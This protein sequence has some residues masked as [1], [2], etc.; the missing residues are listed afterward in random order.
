MIID[1]DT[2]VVEDEDIWKWVSK[3]EAR[4]KPITISS[5]EVSHAAYSSG[6]TKF[7]LID[8][9][10]YGRGGQPSNVYADGTR[11]LADTKARIADMDRYGH[12]VQ[13]IY[14][15][16][17]LNLC[18]KD[19][20]AERAAVRAYNRWMASICADSKG[21]LRWV[22]LPIPRDINA[23]MEELEFG[24]ANG[25]CGVQMRGYEGDRTLDNADFEP[26]FAKASDLDLPI[27]I[28][29]GNGSP[30]YAVIEN[31]RSGFR[32]VLG[33]SMPAFIAFAALMLSDV[34]AKFPKLRIGFIEAASEW[35]PFAIHRCR[36]ML[37]HYGLKD[38]FDTLFADNRFYVTCEADEDI[39]H[40][41]KVTGYD[42]LLVGT[43]YGHADTSTELEAPRLLRGRPDLSPDLTRRI[44]TDNPK[45]F[46]AI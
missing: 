43:D 21:R 28:H 13:I 22:V 26:I 41:A 18:T 1:S 16:L 12:D 40:V 6:S 45:R 27:C 34:P 38:A 32:N 2:H 9:K 15:S 8:G 37:R 24:R 30:S 11:N 7:W 29:I 39:Q 44:V 5:S 4:Y 46:Y 19:V 17:F 31:A 3:A 35:V 33:N 36:K 10:I 23:S 25:A 20:A 14:P 42:N